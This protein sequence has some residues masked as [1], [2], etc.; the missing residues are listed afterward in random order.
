MK[1]IFFPICF[2]VFCTQLFAQ[3]GI[4]TSS[5]NSNALLDLNS[6]TKGLLLP[7]LTIAQ[8]NAIASPTEGLVIYNTTTNSV[9]VYA[10]ARK[11]ERSIL[12]FTS[13]VVTTGATS[14]WQE[15]TP[16]ESGFVTKITLTQNASGAEFAM[17]IHS[18]VTSTSLSS[19]NGGKVIGYTSKYIPSSASGFVNYDYIFS[20]PVFVE[21]NTKY[22]FQITTLSGS[23]GSIMMYGSDVY[24]GNNSY[25]GGWNEEPNFVIYLQPLGDL[26]WRS[27]L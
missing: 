17:K 11:G 5:P 22:W 23:S 6:T 8:R 13:G 16:N 15:F 1:P 20:N 2:F 26:T 24:A 12:S 9:E 18:G 19:L 27:I 4:G 25:V 10:K 21:A 3:V 14:M 7:R